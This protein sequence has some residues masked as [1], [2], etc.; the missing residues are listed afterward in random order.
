MEPPKPKRPRFWDR[1]L[2]VQ[3]HFTNFSLRVIELLVNSITW[4]KT[5]APK[6]E[7]EQTLIGDKVYVVRFHMHCYF[8][9]RFR[10]TVNF[11]CLQI[12]NSKTNNSDLVKEKVENITNSSTGCVCRIIFNNFKAFKFFNHFLVVFQGF[13]ANI[14]LFSRFS[15]R[16]HFV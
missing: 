14:L 3:I 12:Q 4:F 8:W 7:Y 6:Y 13:Q 10:S 1:L 5:M 11:L 15:I 9:M 2:N 16:L